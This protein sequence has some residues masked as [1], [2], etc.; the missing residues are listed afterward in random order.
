M[1]FNVKLIY[2]GFLG[3]KGFVYG[4]KS[5]SL[6]LC[7]KLILNELITGDPW[8]EDVVYRDLGYK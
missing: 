3:S 5:C 6:Q 4:D 2:I 7:P 8:V 1:D